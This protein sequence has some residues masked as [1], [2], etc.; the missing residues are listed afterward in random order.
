MSGKLELSIGKYKRVAGDDRTT[1]LKHPDGHTIKIV[2]AALSPKMKNLVAKLPQH[3]DEGGPVDDPKDAPERAPA[4]DPSQ[5]ITV[6]D[7]STVNIGGGAP[8]D[9]MAE[10][11]R[12]TDSGEYTPV[13][14]A[15]AKVGSFLTH[16]SGEPTGAAQPAPAATPS[17]QPASPAPA[18]AQPAATQ[19]P[20]PTPGAPGGVPSQGLQG[21]NEQMQGLDLKR[22]VDTSQGARA[23]DI[24]GD[25]AK[26]EQATQ[27]HFAELYTD[28]Q[29][30][31]EA[32]KS[33]IEK[34]YIKPESF[35]E[36]RS[37]P[38]RVSS[39]IGLILGGAGAGLTGGPNMALDFLNKQIDRNIRAQ[40][41]N[42]AGKE[43]LMQYANQHGLS[44]QQAL[45]HMRLL[46]LAYYDTQLKEAAMKDSGPQAQA[47]YLMAHG[48]LQQEKDA[49]LRQNAILSLGSG[50][51][52]TDGFS[53]QDPASLVTTLVQ[54]PASQAKVTEEIKDAQNITAIAPKIQDAFKAASQF[55]KTKLVPG[56][57]S[58]GQKAFQALI[59]TTVK[60]TEGTA[61]QAAFDSIKKN[62]MPQFGDSS[63]TL[64]SKYD[65]LKTYLHSKASAPNAKAHGIDLQKF[66]STSSDPRAGFTPEQAAFYRFARANPKDP[67]SAAVLKKLGVQ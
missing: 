27:A 41:E 18:P 13:K 39:A 43:H 20:S 53:D 46:N 3:L 61:R 15:I 36:N 32:Q 33:D 19:A 59:N 37:V 47:N 50:G 23:A 54:D 40:E 7:N 67:R 52:T 1:T 65:A 57:E 24:L 16:K 21:I 58:A 51:K 26:S 29:K 56:I 30:E 22:A 62:M 48:K 49:V 35:L 45:N 8:A 11:E 60:E 9:K 17:P 44:Q 10:L 14:D 66:R 6:G 4:A 12:K 28:A 63:A 55:D 31:Y 34:G 25:Q 42:Q 5:G 38:A 2:H 64:A